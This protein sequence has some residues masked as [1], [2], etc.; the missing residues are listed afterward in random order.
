MRTSCIKHP[1]NEIY[2]QVR[3]WQL[4]ATGWNQ[5]AAAL[6][7]LFEYYHNGRLEASDDP[8]DVSTLLQYHT[9]KNLKERLLRLCSEKT[10][11]KA[12]SLLES[13]GFITIFQN[14]KKSGDRTKFFLFNA[15]VV[16]E[17]LDS[18]YD[19]SDDLSESESALKPY[20][21]QHSADLPE[22]SAKLPDGSANLPEGSGKIAVSTI[23]KEYLKECSKE[24]H[25]FEEPLPI[26][27]C[28]GE[29]VST[30]HT[31]RKPKKSVFVNGLRVEI[32]SSAAALSKNDFV[33][34]ALGTYNEFSPDLWVKHH[35]LNDAHLK[36]LSAA[37]KQCTDR[38][39]FLIRL[40]YALNHARAENWWATKRK[41]F[42][43][44][45]QNDRFFEWSDSWADGLSNPW[46][47]DVA[48]LA[49]TRSG[50]NYLAKKLESRR[51]SDEAYRQLVEEGVLSA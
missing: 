1:R 39:E 18:Q 2:R 51:T 36:K 21:D 45:F 7:G 11:R 23:S 49:E 14:P 31:G 43:T 48:K 33:A 47:N 4:E 17:W 38:D 40:E 8:S 5:C 3:R 35:S 44:V 9:E 24:E 19:H 15:D 42:L 16:Q 10:I 34:L 50:Q 25:S 13:L 46:K 12:V 26:E 29:I 20:R 32:E 28:Q 37:L 30:T 27:L 41:T 22:H 6:L